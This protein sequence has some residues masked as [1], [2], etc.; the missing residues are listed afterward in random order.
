M[1]N[2]NRELESFTASISHDLKA[3]LRGIAG[4]A[5]ILL[6]ESSERLHAEDIQYLRNIYNNA[7]K[8]GRLIEDVLNFSRLHAKEIAR[9]RVDMQALFED[10]AREQEE[11]EPNHIANL[12]I[13]TLPDAQADPTLIRQVAA[14]LLS[15]AFKYSRNR[16][17]AR[18]EVGSSVADG[19]FIY[20]V[21]DNGVGFDML[22]Y[23]K[24]FEAFQRLHSSEVFEGTGIGL[25]FTRRIIQR[26]G[27]RI[28]A[29]SEEGKGATF[30][31]SLPATREDLPILKKEPSLRPV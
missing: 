11:S 10:V 24:L 18:I 17:D 30:Y 20:F 2:A 1:R 4:F 7:A 13:G 19:E 15:N 26:H 29:E 14:N 22:K 9:M 6:T 16:P 27:G 31:F 21:R 8:L 12:N 25:S 5:N 23:E 28:W 3:P